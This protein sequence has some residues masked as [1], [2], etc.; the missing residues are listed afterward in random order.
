MRRKPH[1]FLA[2]TLTEVL[3]MT[4]V[5]AIILAVAVPK[6]S[7]S[8]DTA[9][10]TTCIANLATINAAKQQWAV[11]FQKPGT[12]APNRS[13]IYGAKLYIKV[14]PVCPAGGSYSFQAISL[15][16]TCSI[17]AHSP[18]TPVSPTSRP[19]VQF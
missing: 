6:L 15:K 11:D 12:A 9:Q 10:T 2:Y 18:V 19:A 8:N 5:L 13:D 16:P 17:P 14:E 3:F 1:R 7:S 4:A